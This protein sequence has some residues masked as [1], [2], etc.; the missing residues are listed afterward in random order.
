MKEKYQLK[1]GHITISQTHIHTDDSLKA[2]ATAFFTILFIVAFSYRMTKNSL[3]LFESG[4]IKM[5][6]G[7]GIAVIIGALL[8]WGAYY[9]FFVKD[10]R[11]K[12]ALT[13]LIKICID[14]E[15]N[16]DIDLKLYFSNNRKKGLTFRK[17][18]KEHERFLNDIKK[19]RDCPIE[20]TKI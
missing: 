16:T 11:S 4:G 9:V 1:E 13:D 20:T 2:I 15:D 17:L 8:L 18:E 6:L 14:D 10:W 3:H 12:V 19:Y 5:I 7:V